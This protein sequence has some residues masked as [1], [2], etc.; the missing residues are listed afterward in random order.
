[1]RRHITLFFIKTAHRE[2]QPVCI[3]IQIT[4]RYSCA[5]MFIYPVIKITLRPRSRLKSR[6]YASIMPRSGA[7]MRTPLYPRIPSEVSSRRRRER[8][9]CAVSTEMTI[10]VNGAKWNCRAKKYYFLTFFVGYEE[11]LV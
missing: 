8:G 1:M 10:A 3:R 11:H 4:P 2:P 7:R 9:S 5:L 6:A